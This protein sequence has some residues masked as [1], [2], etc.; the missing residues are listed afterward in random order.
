MHNHTK[1]LLKLIANSI[2]KLGQCIESFDGG[3]QKQGMESL[4]A[5]L[6]DIDHYL[7][8]P[9]TDPIIGLAY[10]NQKEIATQLEAIKTDL[11]AIVSDLGGDGQ[12]PMS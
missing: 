1:D 3:R 2:D 7:K 8:D 10:V 12:Q 5:V 4:A 6:A 11:D 9:H